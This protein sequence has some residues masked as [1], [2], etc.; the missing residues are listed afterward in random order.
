VALLT[1]WLT[2][3]RLERVAAHVTGRVL[4]VGCGYGDLLGHLPPSVTSIDLLDASPLR[5]ELAMS[6]ARE[7]GVPARFFLCDVNGPCTD[8][9]AGPYD[10]VVLGALL[11]HLRPP[12]RVLA[13]A[14]ERLAPEGL[15]VLTTPTPLGGELH[16]LGSY[17][18]LTHPEA[19]HEHF[20]FY[21]ER[22]IGEMLSEASLELVSYG[23]FL[24]GLNQIAVARRPAPRR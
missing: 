4:D 16:R 11:E 2:R 15:L 24:L 23:R 10:T 20:G 14:G 12:I 22:E 7:R 9:P 13:A 5:E 1:G 8:L 17:A 18:G 19:A 3:I 6:R 21:G